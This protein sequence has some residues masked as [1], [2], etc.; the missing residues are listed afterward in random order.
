MGEVGVNMTGV[1]SSSGY[2]KS[3][4][5]IW[6]A[7]SKRSNAVE[8]LDRESWKT[9]MILMEAAQI[10]WSKHLFW[11]RNS[12]QILYLCGKNPLPHPEG[13]RTKLVGVLHKKSEWKT[14]GSQTFFTYNEDGNGY[15]TNFLKTYYGQVIS[16]FS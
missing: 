12:I 13:W 10:P 7:L 5:I 11:K 16:W 3:Q 9:D 4:A 15:R 6:F 8:Y 2:W 1:W 14:Y